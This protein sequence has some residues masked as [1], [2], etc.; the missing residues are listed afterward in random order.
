MGV[1]QH[2]RARLLAIAGAVALLS[3]ACAGPGADPKNETSNAAS[4]TS[5]GATGPSDHGTPD[6][7]DVTYAVH[8][9]D[10]PGPREGALYG[11]DMLLVSAETIPE[12][13]VDRILAIKI[14]GQK[15]VTAAV[16]LSI[17][18]FS[19]ENKSYRVAAADIA[20]YRSFVEQRSADFQEQWDRIADGEVGVA[21]E[22]K[23]RLPL[24]KNGY[25][26]VGSGEQTFPIHVGA[27]GPQI[28]TIDTFVNAAWGE[29]LGL[30]DNNGLVLNTGGIS[31]QALKKKLKGIVGDISMTDLDV[32][33]QY[34][35]DPHAVQSVQYV[36]TFAD[37]VGVYNYR[38]IGGGRVQPDPSW[39]SAHIVT[40]TMP[41]IGQMTCNKF[42]MPQ[43]REALEEIQ[44]SG[45]ADKIHPGEY[46][47]CFYPRFIAG[48][49]TL[50]NHSFGLA[51]DINVPGNQRGTVGQIDRTV[52]GIF[53]RWGFAWGGDWNYTDPMHFEL[54]RIVHAG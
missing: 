46:A 39:V 24:D 19:A 52:V 51:F 23:D 34:G 3:A 16:P 5:T 54:Q 41:I 17:G 32:V 42:M 18:Q 50:S 1:A 20:G 53:K 45:L 28:G 21:E 27:Y 30:P 10:A 9:V 43:L 15:A 6:D 40:E 29:A 8:T 12:G 48:S 31:P 13:V 49:T 38:P 26:K 25:L 33:A 47:G 11:D 36:G 35:L 44:T 22:L 2:G 37:A 4:T 14:A 7:S